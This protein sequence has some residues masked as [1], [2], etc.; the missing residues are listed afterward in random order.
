MNS[1]Q[2]QADNGQLRAVL[3]CPLLALLL[4]G[5]A[6]S[7]ER[8]SWRATLCLM[9]FGGGLALLFFTS[10]YAAW[11]FLFALV[12]FGFLALLAEC[13]LE[14]P[15]TALRHLTGFVRACRWQ[16]IAGSAAFAVGLTPFVMTYAPLIEASS[17]RSFSLV[18]QFAPRPA[19][20][21]NV[22]PGNY[23]W[24]PVLRAL[25]FGFGNREVQTG[26]PVLVMVLFGISLVGLASRLR[27][28]GWQRASRMDRCMLL[29]AFTGGLLAIMSVRVQ[30]FSL[31]YFI[32]RFVPGASALRALGRILVIVDVIIIVGAIHGLEEAFRASSA[33]PTRRTAWLTVGTVLLGILLITEEVNDVQFR[34]DKAGQLEAMSRYQ[35]P[36]A[37]C[38]AFF[39]DSAASDDLPAGYY[40]LDAMMISMRLGLPTVNGYSGV[41]PD[42][43]FGMVP[44]GG[45]Y[46][47]RMLDW[48]VSQGATHG[49][50]RLDA[51][52]AAFRP[53]NVPA[54]QAQFRAQYQAELVATF[55]EIHRAAT[56]FLQDGHSLAELYP[57][58]LEEL[59]YLDRKYGYATGARYHWVQDR[60]WIGA[61]PCNKQAGCFGIGVEGSYLEV[62]DVL[63]AFG[64]EAVRVLFANP[65]EWQANRPI[66]QETAGELMMIFAAPK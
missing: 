21:I 17:S 24:S 34:L 12:M 6:G 38:Q 37:E 26:S 30:D 58:R 40:Q 31:W 39:L 19:D 60:Y 7:A 10:Y 57:Q 5:F 35:Q 46:N 42:E 56:Q 8:T 62:K 44:R 41:Q 25:H 2:F 4:W 48:L 13:I 28:T 18:L 52:T 32:Y 16:L 63:D 20:L 15:A 3:L 66:P 54:E 47:Y 65:T 1:I 59:G 61:R 36:Q 27:R 14:S 64:D 49:I 9:A 51:Q 11:F 33:K 29:L 53:T 45:E 55:S 50:C 43:V 22:S 23:A